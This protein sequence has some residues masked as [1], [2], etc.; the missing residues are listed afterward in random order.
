MEEL[1]KS[2]V[3]EMV[4]DPP[5]VTPRLHGRC[6]RSTL[7]ALSCASTVSGA[8]SPLALESVQ[9]SPYL[10]P[11]EPVHAAALAA[12]LANV[13]VDRSGS[14]CLADFVGP[15]FDF[16]P[17]GLPTSFPANQINGEWAPISFPVKPAVCTFLAPNMRVR[18]T[19]LEY[20]FPVESGSESDLLPLRRTQSQPALKSDDLRAA[21]KAAAITSKVKNCVRGWIPPPPVAAAPPI[22]SDPGSRPPPPPLR[23]LE[24]GRLPPAA[25][26]DLKTGICGEETWADLSPNADDASVSACRWTV[27]L[28]CQEDPQAWPYQYIEAWP[29]A[30]GL[31][32]FPSAWAGQ[33]YAQSPNQTSPEWMPQCSGQEEDFSYSGSSVSTSHVGRLG[34]EAPESLEVDFHP[35]WRD[36]EVRR[37]STACS[38]LSDASHGRKGQGKKRPPPPADEQR[39]YEILEIASGARQGNLWDYAKRDAESST[40]FQRAMELAVAHGYQTDDWDSAY[41]IVMAFNDHIKQAYESPHGNYA[42]SQLFEVMPTFLIAY[43]AKELQMFAVDAAKHRFGCRCM[44][45]LVRYHADSYEPEV[46]EI[47]QM[48]LS[49][50]FS[51]GRCQF[52]THVVQEIIEKGLAEHR[53]AVVSGFQR[54]LFRESKNRFTYR[55]IE[56][57]FQYSEPDLVQEMWDELRSHKDGIRQL[58]ENEFGVKVVKAILHGPQRRAVAEHICGIESQINS[59]RAGRQVLQILQEANKIMV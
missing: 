14:D 13:P 50:V 28:P 53:R 37:R 9:L 30:Q 2:S 54:N 11:Q 33:Y 41:N 45:R 36:Q 34:S 40:N 27:A 24:D 43:I 22:R 42:L 1:E 32:D 25:L 56:Q 15:Q 7:G 10:A 23:D 26:P 8:S 5:Q 12:A 58:I 59:S 19:F 6:R 46:A 4:E 35:A 31:S 38:S 48:L 16:L 20:R 29:S 18:N 57:A 51:L 21:I 47:M 55:I 52:G 49:D 3:L 39:A 44:I 17:K